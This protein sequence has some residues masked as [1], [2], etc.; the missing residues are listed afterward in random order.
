MG[1]LSAEGT[2]TRADI[3][4]L[5]V[6]LLAL[7]VIAGGISMLPGLTALP[8]V[9]LGEYEF[10]RGLWI[11]YGMAT[12]LPVC[13][14]VLALV[15]SRALARRITPSRPEDADVADTPRAGVRDIQSAAIGTFGLLLL[16]VTLPR[17]I[18]TLATHRLPDRFH[19]EKSSLFEDK[20]FVAQLATAVMALLLCTGAGLWVRLIRRFRNLGW[21]EG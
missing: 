5:A 7:Y 14:G 3:S 11:A 2:M 18:A 15:F 10:T 6:R 4:L 9:G 19:A 8:R 12:I 20:F 17:L 16:A 1:I 13:L 21:K